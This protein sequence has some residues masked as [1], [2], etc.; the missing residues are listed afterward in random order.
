MQDAASKLDAS[1]WSAAAD[2]IMTTDLVQK[3]AFVQ[4]PLS[5]G[6]NASILGR[7]AHHC[8]YDAT[9]RLPRH[10]KG[11]RHDSPDHGNGQCIQVRQHC[12]I[13][14]FSSVSLCV[15]S[16][17]TKLVCTQR[18]PMPPTEASIPSTSMVTQARMTRC[19]C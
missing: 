7:F 1:S 14:R 11:L 18:S 12:L 3:S 5:S 19:Q 10:C 4:F 13:A 6:K 2:A 15:I 17:W 8:S 9:E 16:P